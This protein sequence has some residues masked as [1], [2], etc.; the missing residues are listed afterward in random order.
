M[1]MRK[2]TELGTPYLWTITSVG[3]CIGTA[4]KGKIDNRDA[5][6]LKA[7]NYQA[8]QQGD[9]GF[10]NCFCQLSVREGKGLGGTYSGC[11]GLQSSDG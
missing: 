1:R 11:L 2:S 9:Y 7:D 6:C 5:N 8:W 3:M 4:E 10:L